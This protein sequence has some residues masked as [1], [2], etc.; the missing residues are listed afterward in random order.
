MNIKRIFGA[1]LTILGAFGLAY[2]LVLF[3]DTPDGARDVK[4]LVMY[5]VV[6]ALFLTAGIGFIRISRNEA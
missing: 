6:G 2:A 4:A 1:I 3:V 5:G